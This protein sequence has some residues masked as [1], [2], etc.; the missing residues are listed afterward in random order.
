LIW[1]HITGR[2]F[3]Q[4]FFHFH[5]DGLPACCVKAE[6]LSRLF[7]RRKRLRKTCALYPNEN[8]SSTFFFSQV[9][10]NKLACLGEKGKTGIR[11][12]GHHLKRMIG[13]AIIFPSL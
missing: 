10:L 1:E 8:K 3:I 2:C 4:C 7:A 13:G 5:P 11:A 6:I 9:W 12:D